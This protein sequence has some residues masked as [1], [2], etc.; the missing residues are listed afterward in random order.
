MTVS[1]RKMVR[2]PA[3]IALQLL[4]AAAVSNAD[5][6]AVVA[7]SVASAATM[8]FILYP[9][10]SRPVLCLHGDGLPAAVRRIQSTTMRASF[11]P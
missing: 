2:R 9:I 7:S 3:A 11:T 10:I 8:A 4:V 1:V 6:A 5:A